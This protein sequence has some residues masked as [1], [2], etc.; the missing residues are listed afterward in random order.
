MAY[1][2]PKVSDLAP[3]EKLGAF[4]LGK[5]YDQAKAEVRQEL[6]L[7]DA[8]D[9]T[10][11]AVCVGM[12]GSGKTG[13]C[14]SLLEEA[15]IDGIPALAIDPKGD[16]GNLLLGFPDLEPG[17]FE[18]WIDPA[19]ATRK[20]KSPADY[21]ADRAGLWR[22]GL[23]EWGQ[24]G[25]RIARLQSAAEM[26]IY[27]PGSQAGLPLSLLRSFKAPPP[28]L[29]A[30][31]EA[32][33][34]RIS[35]AVSGLLALLGI[36]AD[37][38]R[39]REHILLAKI[40]EASWSAGEDLEIAELIRAIQAPPFSQIGVM[41]LESVYP[42]KDR[43]ALS[44]SLNNLLAAPGFSTWLEGAPLDI[45]KLLWADDGRPRIAILSIAHLNDAERMFF[46]TSLLNE[47]LAW[48]RTQGGTSSLRALL[49]MDE[50]FGYFPPSANPPSKT[51]MLTLLKQARAFGLGVVLATQN[52]VDLDYKGLSNAGTW[53]IGRLQTERDKQRVLDGLEGAS[54][55]SGTGFDRATVDRVLSRL[56][57]R[58]FL[59]NNVH[60]DAPVL[61]HTRWALSYLRGPISRQE[62]TALM[63]PRKAAVAQKAATPM[64]QPAAPKKA[65]ARAAESGRPVL[66][67]GIAEAFLPVREAPGDG[68]LLYR[69][70]LLGE[71]DLHY[72]DR[73]SK[74]DT[75]RRVTCLA[76]LGDAAAAGDLWQGAMVTEGSVGPLEPDPREPARFAALPK[77]A[78]NTKRYAT[79]QKALKTHLYQDCGLTLYTCK[80]LKLTSR[81]DEDE[82]PFRVRLREEA[83]KARDLAIE[84]LRKRYAPKLARLQD[85]IATAEDRLAREEEQYDSRKMETAISIGTTVLGALFGRKVRSVGTVSRAGTAARG[86]SRAA[87][88]RGD[89]KRAEAKILQ[90]H[91]KLADLST[92]FEQEIE[93]RRD[94]LDP[95]L[96]AIDT[97][98]LAPRKSDITVEPVSLA[99]MPWR[100]DAGG[101]SRPLYG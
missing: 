33:R 51:P 81:A 3:F 95:E 75:W 21:A 96:M 48:M 2:D 13:L 83:H 23:A 19:E 101:A 80:A 56:S 89:V 25:R 24:D 92:A 4:Y 63:A 69:P 32:F 45:P 66:P 22:K 47:V 97:V 82:G 37:P 30:D 27:T 85:Q 49:Y 8:K 70:G 40:L 20:G 31:G 7:Y 16:I 5:L 77:S 94:T 12:T 73:A 62:I 15:A 67:P 71:A 44:M 39:D 87:R 76:S 52:P 11:H 60:D 57:S 1:Q 55:T 53:F 100:V 6:L 50:V 46:V 64:K 54:A 28:E 72:T 65:E 88:E 43:F 10:T 93:K 99:W 14:L 26:M 42:A 29:L 79:W 91:E 59:M 90:L 18:P 84:K 38:V 17:D 74:L 36:D 58:V 35:A 86:I 61:F 9:L 98:T 78:R 34:E 68:M 41:D